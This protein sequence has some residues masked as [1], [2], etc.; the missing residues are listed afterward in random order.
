M[1]AENN[2]VAFT[3]TFNGVHDGTFAGIPPTGRQVT[4][5]GINVERLEG[6]KIIEHW[7]QFDLA[8]LTRQINA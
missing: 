7:S 2:L 4:L 1:S 3:W 5:S 6:S 8:A